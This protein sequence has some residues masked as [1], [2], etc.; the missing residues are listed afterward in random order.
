M[1]YVHWL[2][3]SQQQPWDIIIIPV[4]LINR[5]SKT[6]SWPWSTKWKVAFPVHLASNPVL[7]ERQ[8]RMWLSA[9]LPTL[10][11]AS[12]SPGKGWLQSRCFWF[13]RSRV[14]PQNLHFKDVPG[15]GPALSLT[16]TVPSAR[17][18]ESDLPLNLA[19]SL[20]SCATLSRIPSLFNFTPG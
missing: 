15:V 3:Q 18:L 2:S 1:V 12:K 11:C 19:V 14:R 7:G 8:D 6:S 5:H 13:G 20:T 17:A 10:W 9:V 16:G 4:L